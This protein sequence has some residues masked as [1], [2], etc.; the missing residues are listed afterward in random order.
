MFTSFHGHTKFTIIYRETIYEKYQKTRRKYLKLKIKRINTMSCVGRVD[1]CYSEDPYLWW[2]WVKVK[3]TQH[4]LYSPWYCPGQNSGVGAFP[5]SRESSQPRDGTQV[6]RVIDEFFTSW[7]TREALSPVDL[8]DPGTKPE[9]PALQVDSLWEDNCNCKDTPQGVRGPRP[10]FGS[11][12][13][14]SNTGKM[15]LQKVCLWGLERFTFGW[16]TVL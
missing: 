4:G 11:L 14:R 6:S 3:L 5:I 1:I 16:A 7:A 2:K 13:W 12:A 8:P 9:S 15:S 10:T